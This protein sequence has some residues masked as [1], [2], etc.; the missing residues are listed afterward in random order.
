MPEGL[1]T[2]EKRFSTP[3]EELTFLRGEVLRKEKALAENGMAPER[4]EVIKE[5]VSAYAN[6]PVKDAVAPHMELPKAQ[7]EA[8]VL[9]LSPEPHD[10]QIEALVGILQEKGVRTAFDVV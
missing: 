3:E 4:G 6:V 9:D 7:Q 5:T 8:V 2:I 10:K 1:A